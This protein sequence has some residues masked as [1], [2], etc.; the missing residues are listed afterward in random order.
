MNDPLLGPLVPQSQDHHRGLCPGR[1]PPSQ[2]TPTATHCSRTTTASDLSRGQTHGQ[3]S[4]IP[5]DDDFDLPRFLGPGLSPTASSRKVRSSID[6][7]HGRFRGPLPLR[8]TTPRSDTLAL[9]YPI[10]KFLHKNQ[11]LLCS[12]KSVDWQNTINKKE[13]FV[14]STDSLYRCYSDCSFTEGF[15]DMVL[16]RSSKSGFSIVDFSPRRAPNF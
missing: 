12:L 14:N 13:Q 4:T 10:G 2:H 8:A 5:G 15:S 7:D 1:M 16:G 9:K 3:I 6:I 11:W